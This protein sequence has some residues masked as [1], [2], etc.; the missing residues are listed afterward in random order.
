V[1]GGQFVLVELLAARGVRVVAVVARK[2]SPCSVE[3]CWCGR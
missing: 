1:G 3:T 2:P